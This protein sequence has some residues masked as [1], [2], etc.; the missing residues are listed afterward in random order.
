MGVVAR[1]DV[2]IGRTLVY[3]FTAL[4]IAASM[5]ETASAG[6]YSSKMRVRVCSIRHGRQCVRYFYDLT[7]RSVYQT[8]F[9]ANS[10]GAAD[11]S[12]RA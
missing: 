7:T 3:I 12:Y 11:S 2:E 6:G 4:Y 9:V 1:R 5:F 10:S 8:L